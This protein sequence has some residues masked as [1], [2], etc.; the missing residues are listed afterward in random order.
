MSSCYVRNLDNILQP[1]HKKTFQIRVMQK[2]F[3]AKVDPYRRRNSVTNLSFISVVIGIV[4]YN[5]TLECLPISE[6]T[7]FKLINFWIN[8]TKP[9]NC[10]FL[11]QEWKFVEKSVLPSESKNTSVNFIQHFKTLYLELRT[12]PQVRYVSLVLYLF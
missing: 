3:S 4:F 7:Y 2:L 8:S 9:L 11:P 10:N 12:Q 1:K 5:T 6:N